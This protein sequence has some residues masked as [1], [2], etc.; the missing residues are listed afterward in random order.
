MQFV[1]FN[2][3]LLTPALPSNLST[4]ICYLCIASSDLKTVLGYS[5]EE[6]EKMEEGM[7]H[8]HCGMTRRALARIAGQ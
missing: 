5:R 6:K 3:S 7:P 2:V 1:D 4:V 8:I